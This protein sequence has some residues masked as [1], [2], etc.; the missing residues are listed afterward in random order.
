MYGEFI[1]V[2]FYSRFVISLPL[3]DNTTTP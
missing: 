1:V 3:L 2:M